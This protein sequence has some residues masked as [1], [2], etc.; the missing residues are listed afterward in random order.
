MVDQ[1]INLPRKMYNQAVQLKI[2]EVVFERKTNNSFT[3]FF[4]KIAGA[5]RLKTKDI[6]WYVS[7]LI[8]RSREFC[9]CARS[10]AETKPSS[11]T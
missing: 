9:A 8:T 4:V 5:N 11:M 3:L 10:F 2:N 1:R 7:L 6:S